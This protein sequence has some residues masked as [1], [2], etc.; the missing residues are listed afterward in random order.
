[1]HC[2]HHHESF[3]VDFS[4]GPFVVCVCARTGEENIRKPLKQNEC[5]LKSADGTM[6]IGV[7]QRKK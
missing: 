4:F 7:R 1:M 5:R 3:E 6:S 2:R